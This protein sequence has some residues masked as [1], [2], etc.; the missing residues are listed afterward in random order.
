[1]FLGASSNST[2]HQE[3]RS[4]QD[5]FL[6]QLASSPLLWKAALAGDNTTAS[7]LCSALPATPLWGHMGLAAA[8]HSGQGATPGGPG[9]PSGFQPTRASQL[10]NGSTGS[11]S[12]AP[13]GSRSCQWAAS[14]AGQGVPAALRSGP[15]SVPPP[16]LLPPIYVVAAAGAPGCAEQLHGFQAGPSAVVEGLMHCWEQEEDGAEAERWAHRLLEKLLAAMCYH[17][18]FSGTP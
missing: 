7:A 15:G 3:Q 4:Q 5:A 16:D 17:A 8:A 9:C 6:G 13:G 11:S 14:P 10:D 2:K 12:G 18:T 1:M